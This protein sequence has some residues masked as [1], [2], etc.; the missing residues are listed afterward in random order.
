MTAQN[1]VDEASNL[2][3]ERN[4][5]IAKLDVLKNGLKHW[6]DVKG[7]GRRIAKMNA[8]I[9]NVQEEI[10]FKIAFAEVLTVA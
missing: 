1:M 4:A 2:V 9:K 10:D 7:L 5:M 3:N 6:G 8:D